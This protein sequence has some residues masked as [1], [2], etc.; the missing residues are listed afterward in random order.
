MPYANFG[1]KSGKLASNLED[2]Y[3]END[4]NTQILGR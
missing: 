2:E 1:P 3:Y 4:E